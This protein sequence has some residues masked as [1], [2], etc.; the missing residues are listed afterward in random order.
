MRILF[1]A[2]QPFF[3]ERGTPIAVRD[4]VETLCSAG[5]EV[6]LLTL[7]GPQQL[8]IAGMRLLQVR[9]PRWIGPPPIGLSPQKLFYDAT[10]GVALFRQLLE[11]DYDVVHAVEEAVFLALLA[12]RIRPYKIVYDM[13]SI[14]SDQMIEKWPALGRLGGLFRSFERAAMR[15][16]DL[17]LPVCEAVAQPARATA[18][19][20]VHL[21]PDVAEE[22]SPAAV[23]A[24][25]L[26]ATFGVDRPM[27]LYVGN[28]EPYQGMSL[29]IE[30]LS[31]LPPANRCAL[32]VVGGRPEDIE[33]HREEAAQR[34]LAGLV[35]FA[36]PRPLD[37]LSGYLVQA[38]VLCSPR[39]RGVNTPMKVYSYMAAGRPILATRLPSHTQVLDES[40]AVLVEPDPAGIGEGLGRLLTDAEFAARISKAAKERVLAGYS[41]ASFRRRL[42]NAYRRLE[43][44]DATTGAGPG[45]RASAMFQRRSPRPAA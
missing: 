35:H 40:T 23:E 27:A 7:P 16:A 38:D 5:H 42:L 4:A 34:G 10:L 13:D 24:E 14:M 44:Q 8:E 9:A 37:R 45:R 36:G 1:L 29:L 25:D 12:R 11:R 2:P 20:R 3:A 17:L 26:R 43:T 41:R 21:L 18:P 30:G 33:L 28:L 6:D 22:A 15:G 39:L 32:V 19:D 31:R